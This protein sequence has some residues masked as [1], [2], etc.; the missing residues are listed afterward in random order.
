MKAT[1]PT[2]LQFRFQR[3]PWLVDGLTAAEIIERN[4]RMASV[5]LKNRVGIEANGF[6]TPGGFSN[7][8][9]D[10]PDLQRLSASTTLRLA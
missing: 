6:R 4:I 1:K 7:G 3:A 2:D 9:A 5:A 10:R 8:L